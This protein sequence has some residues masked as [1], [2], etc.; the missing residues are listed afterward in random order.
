MHGRGGG[1][2]LA[3]RPLGLYEDGMQTSPIRIGLLGAAR[4]TPKA[5]LE[6]AAKIAEV[7]VTRVA[8]RDRVRA[9]TFAAEHNIDA[10]SES[11]AEL[12]AADDV[13]VVA[14]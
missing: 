10:V 12:V 2:H 4:I 9:E 3:Y 7:V 14:Q 8:A 11:Y 13:D 5:L 6:P 1:T